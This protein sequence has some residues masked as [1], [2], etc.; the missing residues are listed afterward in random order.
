MVLLDVIL[1]QEGTPKFLISAAK[2]KLPQEKEDNEYVVG[3]N[4]CP[5]VYHFFLQVTMQQLPL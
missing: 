4:Y 3:S 2:G 1:T 5:P